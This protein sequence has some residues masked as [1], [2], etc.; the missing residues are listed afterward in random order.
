GAGR[1]A[2]CGGSSMP[3]ARRSVRGTF[4]IPAS[5]AAAFLP[6]LAFF[7][8]FLVEVEAPPMPPSMPAV[9][10]VSVLPVVPALV[11]AMASEAANAA[12]A[13][14]ENPRFQLLIVPLRGTRRSG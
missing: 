12:A 10:V 14:M 1:L 6:F 9:A 11:C 5:I 13:R 3:R 2:A 4:Y 7:L 8:C